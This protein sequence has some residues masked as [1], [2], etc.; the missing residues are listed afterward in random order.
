MF[1][2]V[3]KRSV[4]TVKVKAGWAD[5][6]VKGLVSGFKGFIGYKIDSSIKK[7]QVR[8]EKRAA[9]LAKQIETMPGTIKQLQEE[10]SR[11]KARRAQLQ[12]V[13]SRPDETIQ[14]ELESVIK[15][16]SFKM[17]QLE[18]MIGGADEE[19]KAPG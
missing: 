18:A 11:I 14:K 3:D 9:R 13:L 2:P 10:V 8:E 15:D 12:S 7:Y 17:M 4:K 5:W 16:L 19:K 6:A 1:T